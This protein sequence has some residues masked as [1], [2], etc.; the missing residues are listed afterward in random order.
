MHSR[1]TARQTTF[2]TPALQ[3]RGRRQAS[4]TTRWGGCSF[5]GRILLWTQN[6]QQLPTVWKQTVKQSRLLRL[7]H[8]IKCNLN[9]ASHLFSIPFSLCFPSAFGQS[10]QLCWLTLTA[11][12]TLQAS[13]YRTVSSPHK[14]LSEGMNAL[15]KECD[16]ETVRLLSIDYALLHTPV[17]SVH[18]RG[19][20]VPFY[21][22]PPV[23]AQ[24]ALQGYSGQHERNSGQQIICTHIKFS[25]PSHVGKAGGG[26]RAQG[27]AD[28][29]TGSQTIHS[30]HGLHSKH[31]LKL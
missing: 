27:A 8:P 25:N 31:L 29:V 22:I 26:R 10:L 28:L 14:L 3:L 11:P 6:R 9:Q 4:N 30:A 1:P 24:I 18:F 7:Q 17:G 16:G 13:R 20:C 19:L 15:V 12:D 5:L 23:V 21:P 2:L